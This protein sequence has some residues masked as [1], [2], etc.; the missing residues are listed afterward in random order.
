MFHSYLLRAGRGTV[1]QVATLQ[2]WICQARAR[3]LPRHMVL[4]DIKVAYDRV[5]RGLLWQKCLRKGMAPQLVT[6]LQALF[7]QNRSCV[8]VNGQLFSEFPLESGLLH[9][10]PLSPML[11]SAFID[12]LVGDL[13]TLTGT[14][15][16]RLGDKMFRCLLY[17]P[18]I[19]LMRTSWDG[20][21]RLL[22]ACEDY[23]IKN[24]YRLGVT[25]CEASLSAEAVPLAKA[26]L[27]ANDQVLAL[28]GVRLQQPHRF[29]Y[30]KV[31]FNP[32]GIMSKAHVDAICANAL[33]AACFLQSAGCDG[34]EFDIA[35][36]FRILH[37]FVRP[38]M[39]YGLALLP[40]RW[41]Q[42]V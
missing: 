9:G 29:V 25:K 26:S 28:H 16:M 39:E 35:T 11:Y 13:N 33:G 3:K 30:L 5:D 14:E 10:S 24:R 22:A 31:P 12:D 32:D 7:D 21:K 37:N 19:V 15:T 27:L 36:C 6:M 2:E 38:I 42:E 4:L 20:L 34:H 40:A 41:V 23:P 1:D 17:A 8:R 18:N